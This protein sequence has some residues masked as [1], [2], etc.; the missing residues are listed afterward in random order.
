MR[1]HNFRDLTGQRFG[2]LLCTSY[3]ATTNRKAMWNCSCD[4]GA[5]KI[6]AGGSLVSG[7]LKLADVVTQNAIRPA[8]PTAKHRTASGT[9]FIGRFT[10]RVAAALSQLTVTTNGT[11]QSACNLS[12]QT[13]IASGTR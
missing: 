5:T 10:M 11:E 1:A 4:C 13:S 7:K 9:Q 6:V 12:L 3:A 2:K 8:L